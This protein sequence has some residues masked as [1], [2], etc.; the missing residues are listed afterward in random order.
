MSQRQRTTDIPLIPREVLFGNPDKAMPKVSH[1]GKQLAFLAEVL[2][3]RFEPLGRD[4]EGSSITV[5]TGA[6]HVPGLSEHL[7]RG[8]Q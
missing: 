4:F 8:G 6:H 2:G 5:P 1:D 3:G 7:A